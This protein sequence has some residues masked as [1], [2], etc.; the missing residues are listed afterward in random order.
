MCRKQIKFANRIY[1]CKNSKTK[2]GNKYECTKNMAINT[3]TKNRHGGDM[4]IKTRI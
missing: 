4:K 2:N 3:K 1:N